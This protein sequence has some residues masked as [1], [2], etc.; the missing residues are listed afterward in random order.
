MFYPITYAIDQ[1]NKTSLT[2]IANGLVSVLIKYLARSEIIRTAMSHR[3]VKS[4]LHEFL[5]RPIIRSVCSAAPRPRHESLTTR[6]KR[7]NFHCLRFNRK[8]LS[9]STF[10]SILSLCRR[11]SVERSMMYWLGLDVERAE[12]VPCHDRYPQALA[13]QNMT[14]C[15]AVNSLLQNAPCF[16][17]HGR[18][19]RIL[20][21]RKTQR[22]WQP[23]ANYTSYMTSKQET[24]S[25]RS[26]ILTIYKLPIRALTHQSTLILAIE[27]I[28]VILDPNTSN[29]TQFTILRI[30]RGRS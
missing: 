19:L 23:V 2:L 15:S 5:L 6:R 17:C 7:L 4:Q 14:K 26:V 27:T 22:N 30:N 8:I 18:C 24:K 29:G 25:R 10:H 20:H 28:H 1:V 3:S 16:T 11:D 13:R 12:W 9:P 21:R